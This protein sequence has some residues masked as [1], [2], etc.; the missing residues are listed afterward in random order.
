MKLISKILALVLLISCSPGSKNIEVDIN[1]K[2]FF[3]VIDEMVRYR[4]NKVSVVQM[5]SMPV[6]KS[7]PIAPNHIGSFDN[8][9]TPRGN[10]VSYSKD[11]FISLID[12]KLIDSTDANFMF[13]NI[14]P[15]IVINIDSNLI[16]K[17]TFSKQKLDSLFEINMDYAYDYLEK[18]FGKSCFIRVGTPVFN[19]GKTILIL[20]VDYYCGP[21]NGL[22]YIFILKKDKDKWMLI[23]ELGT[24]ES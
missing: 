18:S 9:P 17:P 1:Q 20:G 19:K 24:W 4:L 11:F 10:M 7:I 21:L 8:P 16:S 12:Q 5:E 13:D 15:N 2:E 6:Y 3:L 14:D 23:E 22:G